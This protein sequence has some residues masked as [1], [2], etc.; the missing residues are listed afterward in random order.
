MSNLLLMV[1]D[2]AGVSA[3]TIG[4]STGP[5]DVAPLSDV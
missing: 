4:D 5:L 3:D 2:K 1:L